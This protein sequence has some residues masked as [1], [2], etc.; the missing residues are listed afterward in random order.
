M[1]TEG[2]QLFRAKRFDEAIGA[3]R[4]QLLDGTGERLINVAGLG[5]ALIAAGRY[6]EAIPFLTEA[7]DREKRDVPGTTGRD[8]QIAVCAWL[9]GNRQR[10]LFLMRS[11]VMGL[12]EGSITYAND[13]VGGLKQGLLLNYM[14][15]TASC[16]EDI[17]IAIAFIRELAES[18]K[19][20]NWPGPVAQFLL[21]TVTL[22]GALEAA[23]GVRDIEQASRIAASDLMRRRKLTNV[24]FNAAASARAGADEQQCLQYMRACAALENPLIEYEWHLARAEANS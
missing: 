9:S 5:E 24:L 22:G 7:G 17:G 10:G 18:K 1:I 3:F 11:M 19:V 8:T 2:Q 12:R 23:V 14:A 6:A 4:K 13:L 16:R 15:L 21:G 20:K